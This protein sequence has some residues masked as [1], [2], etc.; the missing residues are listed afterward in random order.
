VKPYYQDDAVV[1]YHE[2]ALGALQTLRADLL[3][4]DPQY[5]IG[6]DVCAKR[7]RKSG[8]A[9]G[10]GGQGVDR[11]WI[12]LAGR[13]QA[14]FDPSPFLG[15]QSVILWGA[16]NYA[17]RLPDSRGWLVWDKLGDKGSSAFGDCELAWTNLDRSIR[18][19][20]QLWRGVVREGEEN[21]A[22]GP[23]VHP[24]QKPKALMIFCILFADNARSIEHQTILD[25][26]MGSGTTLRAAKDLGR[27][28]IGI[29]IEE[30]Y[31]EIAARRMAQE[32]LPL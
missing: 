5:G 15:F 8:L 13:D 4:T 6:F 27:K 16:N 25:P 3:L 23:K 10:T 24:C 26:F 22:N 30:R 2:T 31:C 28:A 19:H 21:A 20:R 1:I 7:S 14:P 11:A 9:W 29:E 12:P 17:S 32:V 18:I